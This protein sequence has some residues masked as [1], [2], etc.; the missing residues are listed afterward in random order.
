MTNSTIRRTALTA[1]VAF[2][3]LAATMALL[4]PATVGTV[5]AQSDG[6]ANDSANGTASLDYNDQTLENQSVVV[7]EANLSN[8]GYVAIFDEGGNLIGH[9]DYL[10]SGE[11][12]NLTVSLNESF[13]GDQVT[14][15]TAYTDDGNEMFNES[16]DAAYQEG[17]APISSTA[18]VT[19]NGMS[20]QTTT[21]TSEETTTES[22][23]SAE[24]T[25]T[26]GEEAAETTESSETTEGGE[27]STT[28]PGFGIV[29]ALVGLFGAV[30]VVLRR[31]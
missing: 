22:G 14:I 17:G 10:E 16:A 20:E 2:T 4:A 29:V 19:G 27:T 21:S 5:A 3:V 31:A 6:A 11:Q 24:E 28:G 9:T 15:A 7:E 18:Y 1:V 13:T 25:T 8:G 23:E 26:E 12:T 30:A